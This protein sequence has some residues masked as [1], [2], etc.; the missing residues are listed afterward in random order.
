M[1]P[2]NTNDNSR[3]SIILII[4]GTIA[5]PK[6]ILLSH[7]IRQAGYNLYIIKSHQADNFLKANDQIKCNRTEMFNHQFYGKDRPI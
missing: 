4:S 3:F 5:A 6:S 1:L 7:K 2:L